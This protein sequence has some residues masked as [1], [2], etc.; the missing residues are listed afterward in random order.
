MST[1]SG[2]SALVIRGGTIVEGGPASNVLGP[3]DVWI[4]GAL[5]EA[6]TPP[7]ERAVPA[8]CDVVD[9]RDGIVM[10]GLVDTHRHLWQTPLRGLGADLT[11]PEYRSRLRAAFGPFMTPD[12]LY[13]ATL[14]GALEALDGGV[15]TVLDW[16]HIMNSPEHADASV[17]ALRASGMR[18]V[19]A[20]STPNDLEAESW[21]SRS[22]RPHP[23]DVRRVREQ[24]L[25]SDDGIV[26][27]AFGARAPH[28][29][30]RETMIHDWHLARELDLR[31]SVDGGLGGGKWG[32]RHYPIRLLDEAGLLGSD[33]T[34]VHCNNLAPDEYALIAASGGSISISPSAEMNVGHG[35]PATGRALAA[36]IKPALSTDYVTQV[37]GDMFETMRTLLAAERGLQ[38]R[39]AFEAGH[40]VAPWTLTTGTVLALATQSGAASLGLAARTGSLEPGK[41]ADIVV[42]GCDKLR[43]TPV[44]DPVATIVLFATAADVDAVVVAGE[45]R[46]REG[47]LVGHDVDKIR[48]DL[49]ALRDRL[50]GLGRANQKADGYAAYAW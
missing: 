14:A 6:V 25:P 32:P 47:R 44:N 16:A 29:L 43:L 41:Q 27:M 4:R 26:T 2:S 30:A 10:P 48:R 39:E 23:A 17:A 8:G 13:I 49:I 18:S 37:S 46:K 5:I 31:I 33:T 24:V 38:A 1:S 7:G 36:G 28:L 22:V 21:Y 42:V 40:G 34:Y 11:A 20:F 12:D 9:A 45:V 35:L 50:V 3:G 15:T 19:F